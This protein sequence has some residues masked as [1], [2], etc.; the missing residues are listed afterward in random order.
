[1]AAPFSFPCC[2]CAAALVAVR[3]VRFE[4]VPA[5]MQVRPGTIPQ[6]EDGE[7]TY[8]RQAVLLL[9]KLFHKPLCKPSCGS[10]PIEA[11]FRTAPYRAPATRA[12]VQFHVLVEQLETDCVA[13]HVGFEPANPS[14]SY[15]IGFA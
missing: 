14:A 11:A 15:L 7:H 3:N 9:P 12:L 6:S 1:M 8:R 13:G 10:I 4:T 5:H 2:E